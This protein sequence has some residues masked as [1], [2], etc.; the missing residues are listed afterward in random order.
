MKS[1]DEMNVD[2]VLLTSRL[3]AYKDYERKNKINYKE[4]INAMN[5]AKKLMNRSIRD[6]K[7]VEQKIFKLQ[8][9]IKATPSRLRRWSKDNPDK[10]LNKIIGD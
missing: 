3:T 9:K 10:V 2:L 1:I 4:S 5:A 8:S 6:R 7:L